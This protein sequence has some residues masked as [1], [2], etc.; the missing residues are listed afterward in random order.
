MLEPL[1]LFLPLP[2]L[3]GGAGAHVSVC[4]LQRALGL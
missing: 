1:F 2:G 3:E 4:V